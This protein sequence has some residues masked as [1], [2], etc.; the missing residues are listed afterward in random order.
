MN[1]FSWLVVSFI[2]LLFVPSVGY[3]HG[4]GVDAKLK[5]DLVRVEVYYDDD[6]PAS[7]AKVVVTDVNGM[8]I[9]EG[10]TDKSGIWSFPIPKAGKYRI[11]A[12]GGD[13]H[14]A[15]TSITIT[16]QAAPTNPKLGLDA[17]SPKNAENPDVDVVVS[18]G[19][20]RSEVTGSR[21]LAMVGIGL[22]LIA[23][24]FWM[25]KFAARK[26]RQ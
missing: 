26:Q 15:K 14:L 6:T 21:R 13:G 12:D 22:I 18:E 17:E 25:M 11:T 8:M 9:A 1:R 7:A 10:T 2:A 16:E 19:L 5:A 20:T 3:S 4:M 23:L 24:I